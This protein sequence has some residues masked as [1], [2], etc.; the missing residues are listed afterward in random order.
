[1]GKRASSEDIKAEHRRQ[2][3]QEMSGGSRTTLQNKRER[4]LVTPEQLL[5]L[6]VK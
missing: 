3:R 6:T 1:M 5:G 4:C 2:S